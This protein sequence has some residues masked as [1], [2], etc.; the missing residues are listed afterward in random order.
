MPRLL[1]VTVVV[2]ALVAAPL[3]ARALECQGAVPLPNDIR[4][5][6]PAADVPSAIARFAGAWSGAWRD[7]NGRDT[8]CNALVVEEVH[9]NGFARVVYGV[10]ASTAPGGT[11]PYVVR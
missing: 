9:A 4:L 7:T 2:L 6:R 5:V 8:Q 11:M 1:R 10:S 3:S